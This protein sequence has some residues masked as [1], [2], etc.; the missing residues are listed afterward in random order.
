MI[1][2]CL[3]ILDSTLN[4]HSTTDKP[5][6]THKPR[7]EF[8]GGN[9]C[10]DFTNTVDSRPTDCRKELLTSYADLVRWGEEASV[11][12][13]KEADRLCRQA[14]EAPGPAKTALRHALQLR[15]AI[16]AIFSAGA[17]RRAA[18]GTSLA[19]LNI[20][21][22]EAAA[23]MRLTRANRNFTWE[24]IM[25]DNRLDSILWPVARSAAELLTSH[26]LEHV[27]RCASETCAWLFLDKTRNH[28]RRWCE[29]RTCGNRD[30]AR[31][32]YQR[33]KG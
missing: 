26:E 19:V 30:K 9:L 20:A 31:R 3:R 14:N 21:V 22:Q 6:M 13:Q 23:H 8:T 25:P 28:R 5:S 18:P 4:K 1:L 16:Y 33:K 2:Q 29:M 12:S 15:E 17:E 10:L 24:W 27:R 11:L 32:Y 7:F